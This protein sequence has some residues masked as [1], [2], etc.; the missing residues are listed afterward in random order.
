ME[1][2]KKLVRK[3]FA[4]AL[5]SALVGG[6]ALALPIV[7]SDSGVTANAYYGK[8]KP[9]NFTFDSATGVLTIKKG[10]YENPSFEWSNNGIGYDDVI[11]K[12]TAE[13]G[14]VFSGSLYDIGFPSEVKEIDFSRVDVSKVTDMDF[15]FQSCDELETISLPAG[16]N[17]DTQ[18]MLKNVCI[19]SEDFYY[20]KGKYKTISGWCK[21][22]T[23]EIASGTELYASLSG[24]ATYVYTEVETGIEFTYKNHVLTLE[25]GRYCDFLY[26]TVYDL[27]DTTGGGQRHYDP[28]CHAVIVKSGVELYGNAPHFGY[29]RSPLLNLVIESGV[30]MSG[31]TNADEMFA[32]CRS[33][34]LDLRTMK[35]TVISE[36]SDIFKTNAY[37]YYEFFSE[38]IFPADTVISSDMALLNYSDTYY[39]GAILG[40]A[41][42]SSPDK[43]I[44]GEKLY[45]EFTSDGSAYIPVFN[46]DFA[47]NN[48]SN[49][50]TLFTSEYGYTYEMETDENNTLDVVS[51]NSIRLY[52]E[53]EGGQGGYTYALMYKKATSS[54]WTK[55]G[56]KYG[57]AKEGFF[58]PKS[59]VKY[60]VRIIVK[61]RTGKT[62]T[63]NFTVNVVAPL[64]NNT[65][66]NAKTVKLGEKI[67]LKG[68]AS[69]GTSGYKYAFY[70]KK[71]KSNN[72]IAIKDPYTTKSAAFKPGTATSY[73]VKSVVKDAYG[74]MAEKVYTVNV[75]K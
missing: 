54:T 3:T 43:I 50:Y 55:I 31:I 22:G 6:T 74:R 24:G 46:K 62:K 27:C 21:K 68:A 20:T 5:C 30:D 61:D 29:D 38:I 65:T 75:T 34:K 47:L 40:W 66:V 9:L 44:S 17:I 60:D 69:G 10:T 71:S 16:M 59:N 73:D 33:N 8:N 11:N 57:D 28:D 7:T 53:G 14:V 36:A 64:K 4:I 23:N 13:K 15:I 72:W 58:T 25:K 41:K 70:Y 49:I 32:N 35:N 37:N 2:F 12:I 18:A 63:K 39:D 1:K 42:K 19:D 52:A 45:A 26:Q 48:I 56:T 67:V 51:G